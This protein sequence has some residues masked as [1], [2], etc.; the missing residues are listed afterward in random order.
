MEGTKKQKNKKKGTIERKQHTDVL[1]Y[2]MQSL[3]HRYQTKS[4]RND[5]TNGQCSQTYP[6]KIV[7]KQQQSLPKRHS[8][9]SSKTLRRPVTGTPPI[10]SPTHSA[11]Q[12]RRLLSR[13]LLLNLLSHLL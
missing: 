1:E 7:N 3:L 10:Y 11:S 12:Q 8:G 6:M 5:V 2:T 4:F 13:R 9:A